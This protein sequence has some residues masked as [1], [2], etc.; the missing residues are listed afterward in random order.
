MR[1]L[2][3]S[4]VVAAAAL[5]LAGCGSPATRTLAATEGL[6]VDVGPLSY[7]VQISRYLNPGDT[8]DKYYLAGL[9]TGA[10]QA[11]NGDVWF[12]VFMRIK[13][14]SQQTATP[15]SDFMIEDTE[16]NKFQPTALDS[17]VNPYAY[18]PRPIGPAQ[19]LPNPQTPAGINPIAGALILFR[20]KV[21]DL[22]NRPLELHINQTGQ[23][24]AI[25]E[26]DL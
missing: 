20:L 5:A 17:K 1:R 9:P 4:A 18:K 25:V 26:L 13:N 2:A 24:E 22:Q 3:L 7:Q 11:G 19:W 16:G 14:Y 10:A 21:A 6:Y 12:G 8:E 23:H 15:A